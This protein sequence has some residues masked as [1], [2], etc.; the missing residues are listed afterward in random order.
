LS[1]RLLRRGTSLDGESAG[2][3]QWLAQIYWFL[4]ETQLAVKAEQELQRLGA[5]DALQ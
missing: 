1:L 5:T 3:F 4:D 2:T